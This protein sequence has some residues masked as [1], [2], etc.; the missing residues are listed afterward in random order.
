M[1]VKSIQCANFGGFSQ[2][3]CGLDSKS[4]FF[5][6]VNGAGKTTL[7]DAMNTTITLGGSALA[8]N[9][10]GS[11]AKAGR[12]DIKRDLPSYCL[13]ATEDGPL[14]PSGAVSHA[15][16]TLAFEP[17]DAGEGFVHIGFL[18][19][20]EAREG[21]RPRLIGDPTGFVW[22][23]S[24]PC[25]PEHW[26]WRADANG[27][28]IPSSAKDFKMRAKADGRESEIF[29]NTGK[30]EHVLAAARAV[31]GGALM[32]EERARKFLLAATKT[33]KINPESNPQDFAKEALGADTALD[34]KALASLGS[35]GRA[36]EKAA[37]AL[38]EREVSAKSM[39]AVG[40]K[41]QQAAREAAALAVTEETLSA[42]REDKARSALDKIRQDRAAQLAAAAA[43]SIAANEAEA[44]SEASSHE[45]REID[46]KLAQSRA[47]MG[48]TL[49]AETAVQASRRK[50]DKETALNRAR[51]RWEASRRSISKRA[52]EFSA[53]SPKASQLILDWVGSADLEEGIQDI[54]PRAALAA[55]ESFGEGSAG[56]AHCDNARQDLFAARAREKAAKDLA[57]AFGKGGRGE[58]PPKA[59]HALEAL[60]AQIPEAHPRCLCDAAAPA[61]GS[62]PEWVEALERLMGYSR[63]VILVD[64][65][66]EAKALDIVARA[67]REPGAPSSG[68]VAEIARNNKNKIAARSPKPLELRAIDDLDCGG[69]EE[70]ASYLM[71][72]WG[73]WQKAFSPQDFQR[74]DFCF[75]LDGRSS[76]RSTLKG[77]HA[78]NPAFR[79]CFGAAAAVAARRV[80]EA[81]AAKASVE[82]QKAQRA[83]DALEVG[84][85][86]A[87]WLGE[88][89]FSAAAMPFI[90]ARKEWALAAKEWEDALT[91]RDSAERLHASGGAEALAAELELRRGLA[92]AKRIALAQ[93]VKRQTSIKAS[94][95]TRSEEMGRRE[96]ELDEDL[97]KAQADCAQKGQRRA[98]WMG[99][100][101]LSTERRVDSAE[102]DSAL[103]KRIAD[104]ASEVERLSLAWNV[105]AHSHNSA[106]SRQAEEIMRALPSMRDISDASAFA[107]LSRESRDKILAAEKRCDVDAR[108]NMAAATAAME[109][110]LRGDICD[111]AINGAEM[112]DMQMRSLNEIFRQAAFDG[113]HFVLSRK[114]LD[115]FKRRLDTFSAIK[116]ASQADGSIDWAAL[117]P[118][119]KETFEDIV[120]LAKAKD[121]DSRRKLQRICDPIAGSLFEIRAMRQEGSE[122]PR[123][124][125]SLNNQK[126]GSGGENQWIYTLLQ[127]LI[128][129]SRG[130]SLDKA[131]R[132]KNCLRFIEMDEAFDKLSAERIRALMSFFEDTLGLQIL[133][134]APSDKAAN[135]ARL[136]ETKIDVT[137]PKKIPGVHV[138]RPSALHVSRLDKA[139]LQRLG[140]AAERSAL[141]RVCSSMARGAPDAQLAKIAS[142]PAFLAAREQALA[143][144]ESSQGLLALAVMGE[145]ASRAAP[146]PGAA[147]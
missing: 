120:A 126:T 142:S 113:M 7:L 131:G 25:V 71:A 132:L 106:P 6:G 54:G 28:K 5:T 119:A 66:F 137:R 141:E 4:S 8:Y 112:V 147:L 92:E 109:S 89:D 51:E 46:A 29:Y 87:S 139:V 104:Q 117:P 14:R 73:Q 78:A 97:R 111:K 79:P 121:D 118:S 27:G 105:A 58:I 43:A 37:A 12:A 145:Q 138:L 40:E 134:A 22:H 76:T 32:D 144:P 100:L 81:D 122:P 114:P 11:E 36:F 93:D 57:A 52:G 127:A 49:L 98:A 65:G 130:G 33:L 23:S 15:V 53:H 108:K 56:R 101:D 60:M 20:A 86:A 75:G 10:A 50:A 48:T 34:A 77:E 59:M 1:K 24:S 44:A 64:D 55:R 63:F 95:T 41:G 19:E 62:T 70:A 17:I 21:G 18:A 84:M 80:A 72:K 38:A 35:A 74:L 94:A 26:L 115:E 140:A 47:G 30:G 103:A 90:E 125:F 107:E 13:G 146:S 85:S 136:F 110:I 124:L 69:D 116:G 102:S 99:A 143:D 2:A 91:E 39:A 88:F 68:P 96:E 67:A 128:A 83:L 129:A 133:A 9:V 42:R 16:M 31:T 82:A 45:L 123:Q 61:K 135:L 3:H